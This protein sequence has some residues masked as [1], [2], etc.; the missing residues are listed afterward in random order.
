MEGVRR[1]RAMGLVTIGFTGG[2]GGELGTL[3]DYRLNVE[4]SSTPR[5]QE[6][7]IVAGHI[8]CELVEHILC[9]SGGPRDEEI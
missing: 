8:I 7:H 5:I 4:S 9:G 1:A 2:N 3:C 6:V